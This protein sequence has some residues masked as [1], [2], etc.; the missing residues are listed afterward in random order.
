MFA[1]ILLIAI[2]AQINNNQMQLLGSVK[3]LLYAI[4]YSALVQK[5]CRSWLRKN[6]C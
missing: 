3:A 6:C 4:I 1:I 2:V 5:W